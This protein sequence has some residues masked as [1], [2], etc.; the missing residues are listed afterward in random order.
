MGT[1]GRFYFREQDLAILCIQAQF[2][3]GCE[4]IGGV[5]DTRE[6]RGPEGLLT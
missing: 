3:G 6:A 4:D 1:K 5:R 2:E